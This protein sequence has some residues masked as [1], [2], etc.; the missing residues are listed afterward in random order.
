MSK[1]LQKSRE[2]TYK[3]FNL[4]MRRK[5]KENNF[6]AVLET[7]RDL[8]NTKCVV[9]SYGFKIEKNAPNSKL[10]TPFFDQKAHI[11]LL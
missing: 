10:R 9:P 3:T 6:K 5:A 8:M 4:I 1:T 2:D 11:F 7:I